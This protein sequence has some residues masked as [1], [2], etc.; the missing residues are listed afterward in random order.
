MRITDQRLRDLTKSVEA[1]FF[2]ALRLFSSYFC[3]LLFKIL[4]ER[5]RRA[6]HTQIQQ[7]IQSPFCQ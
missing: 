4:A 7:G 3:G 5:R 6:G 1:Q 2:I